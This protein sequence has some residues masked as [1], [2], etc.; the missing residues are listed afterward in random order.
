MKEAEGT[1]V[2]T[3]TFKNAKIVSCSLSDSLTK[4]MEIQFNSEKVL[5]QQI[6]LYLT[7]QK[8]TL[9]EKQIFSSFEDK[10]DR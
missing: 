9:I 7:K 5:S 8:Q 2:F 10:R 1:V 6:V 4:F 3:P